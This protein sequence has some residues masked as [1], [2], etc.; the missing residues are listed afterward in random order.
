MKKIIK[1]IGIFTSVIIAILLLIIIISYTNHKIQL[2]KEKEL[3]IPNG[4]IV[5]VNDHEIHTY[6]EGLGKN[7]LVFM[8]G[9][10]TSSP[11][12]D[13][14]SL[15]S[16][17]SNEYKI[18]VVEKSGYGF[19]QDKN[20]SRDIHTL[21]EETRLALSKSGLE[22]PYILYPHSMSGIEALYWSE[23]YPEEVKAIIGL[24]MA[25]PEIYEDFPINPF[26]I[27][28]S[29]FGSNIGITRFFPSIVED[30]AA[31]KFG[32]LTEEE[33]N[34][35][36]AVFYRRTLTKSMQN[37]IKEI[38]SN[39]EI[40]KQNKTSNVPMLFFISNGEG[41]GWD[42]DKWIN[43]QIEYIESISM[44]KYIKL[45]S[46]HYVH[47]IKYEKIAEESIKF[48]EDL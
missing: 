19:S 41:T 15:Y 4:Q 27:R 11:V 24:D 22:P 30:S 44:G 9:G 32:N 6:T 26:I 16:L 3:F 35:Y 2:S 29:A 23:Q 42:K 47:D 45:D 17:F 38:Q 5:L 31:I 20:S 43:S 33:K 25:V 7:T 34:I 18:A 8:S 37:E 28:L 12:L 39:A 21:V 14:K 1:I 48:I 36:R 40:V 13:F 10:G 46:G